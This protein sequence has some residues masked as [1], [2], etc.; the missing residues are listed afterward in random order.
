MMAYMYFR[1]KGLHLPLKVLID[2]RGWRLVAQSLVPVDHSTLV[3]G[4]CDGCKNVRSENPAFNEKM[5]RA[6][7]ILNL[8][9]EFV[10]NYDRQQRILLHS[11]CDVEG[12]QGKDG[13]FYLVDTAR[14]L[15]PA[16]P[17]KDK[18]NSFLWNMLRP[19]LVK[20]NPDPLS[21]DSF[22]GFFLENKLKHNE[23]VRAATERLENTIVPNF[24]QSLLSVDSS[25]R[26]RKSTSPHP[27]DADFARI[28]MS[29]HQNGINL[30][31]LGLVYNHVCSNENFP[32]S[33]S[34]TV[35]FLQTLLMT[36]MVARV[37]KH[38][39]RRQ[40]RKLQSSDASKFITLVTG[41][42]N[43]V[44]GRSDAALV[45]WQ[46][47]IR[48]GLEARFPGI[49]I[50]LKNV[51]FSG[52]S[53]PALFTRLQGL[54]GVELTEEINRLASTEK[55]EKK[56]G[57]KAPLSATDVQSV[58]AIVK[59]IHRIY[60]DEG[61]ALSQA[62]LSRGQGTQRDLLLDM[63]KSLYEESLRVKPND[64]RSLHNLGYSLFLQATSSQ[65]VNVRLVEQ[66]IDMFK[67]AVRLESKDFKSL[68]T[69]AQCLVELGKHKTEDKKERLEY[70][71]E[72]LQKYEKAANLAKKAKK[73]I[74]AKIH[75]FWGSAFLARAD[76][77]LQQ[78]RDSLTQSGMSIVPSEDDMV[79]VSSSSSSIKPAPPPASQ[80]IESA[81]SHY[82]ESAKLGSDDADT[83]HN[84]AVALSK[85]ARMPDIAG[86]AQAATYFEK[87]CALFAK[88]S[89]IRP[90][91]YEI[92]F[93]WGNALFRRARS[94]VDAFKKS[95]TSKLKR[96]SVLA[97]VKEIRAMLNSAAG[98]YNSTLRNRPTYNAAFSN[99]AHAIRVMADLEKHFQAILPELPSSSNFKHQLGAKKSKRGRD[100]AIATRSSKRRKVQEMTLD[101]SM[102]MDVFSNDE[103]SVSIDEEDA[104]RRADAVK[105][106]G[107]EIMALLRDTI[108]K[109]PSF[110]K[111]NPLF[112]LARVDILVPY[113]LKSLD[114]IVK[115]AEKMPSPPAH[116]IHECNANIKMIKDKLRRLSLPR[117][118]SGPSLSDVT[119]SKLAV[120]QQQSNEKMDV[121]EEND[122][123]P[124]SLLDQLSDVLQDFDARDIVPD[125]VWEITDL[126]KHRYALKAISQSAL[127]QN[128]LNHLLRG[129]KNIFINRHPDDLNLSQILTGLPPAMS[130]LSD[131][132]NDADGE[133][134]EDEDQEQI[135]IATQTEEERK[136]KKRCAASADQ[137]IVPIVGY[138]VEPEHSKVFVAMAWVPSCMNLTEVIKTYGPLPVDLVRFICAEILLA[139]ERFHALHVTAL[140]LSPQN[141]LLDQE[142][143][144]RVIPPI[145]FCGGIDH[146]RFAF[147]MAPEAIFGEETA[148]VDYWA[149]GNLVFYLLTGTFAFTGKTSAEIVDSVSQRKAAFPVD[150]PYDARDICQCLFNPDTSERFVSPTAVKNH[151][152]F[153]TIAWG[154]LRKGL[155]E[156]PVFTTLIGAV[157]T[158]EPTVEFSQTLMLDGPRNDFMGHTF[159]F[160]GFSQQD[161]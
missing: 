123:H 59:H 130:Q 96:E 109:E 1:I 97:S 79:V 115:H 122:I 88:A 48:Q 157:G 107:K 15:P 100:S 159:V 39:I 153:R 55:F 64:I 91:S 5:E 31:Y 23:E 137:F 89:Q 82:E 34:A 147:L 45:M 10:Y 155:V 61:Y 136:I 125:S 85:R 83:F 9:S 145:K 19:E 124:P 99:W 90:Y 42:F 68:Y 131:A 73:E 132:M 70:F 119:L 116:L 35:Q 81:L 20:S 32:G 36:E 74:R 77:Q 53:V 146:E 121:D 76:L 108:L 127:R 143:H 13:R 57:T 133:D 75:F 41:C 52:V 37:V 105:T 129:R 158:V 117:V 71:D 72:A 17:I 54:T 114:E 62:A 24:A 80:D 2:Y 8:Q 140:I 111:P 7:R 104:E 103:S 66:A 11:S 78:K 51:Q 3:Y 94:S 67:Q 152:F 46:K 126:E 60:F 154:R 144:V 92:H 43:S 141:I 65:V 58:N 150:F 16:N 139:I 28:I 120:S 110:V 134:T 93:N 12:H 21:A 44:F 149:L 33:D 118:A 102:E 27:D 138:F 87:A 112:D 50:T 113:V 128:C 84:Y 18:P 40:M 4:S 22:S 30:R 160:G 69:W 6:A 14:V 29:M 101:E 135:F 63:A 161:V 86:T 95:K 47:T 56:I 156:S 38:E 25:F 142:G 151:K 106:A 49:K 148:M 26:R 98:C